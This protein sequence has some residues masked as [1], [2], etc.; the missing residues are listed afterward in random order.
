[1]FPF[2]EAEWSLV[3]YCNGYDIVAP[4]SENVMLF[5]DN[6]EKYHQTNNL[7]WWTAVGDSPIRKWV[8]DDRNMFVEVCNLMLFGKNK[9]MDISNLE[10]S[11]E[12]FYYATNSSESFESAKLWYN[13]L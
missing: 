5:A 2:E 10:K 4:T 13:S 8:F 6:D 9:Y 7:K 12:D 1:M 3:T 11:V